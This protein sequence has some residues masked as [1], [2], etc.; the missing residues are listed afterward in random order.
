MSTISIRDQRLAGATMLPDDFIDYYMPRANGDFVKIYLFLLRSV[1]AQT[2]AP[3]ISSLAD[4]FRL[5]ERDVDRA[6]RYWQEAGLLDLKY[7]G[8]ELDEIT[9]LPVSQKLH[10]TQKDPVLEPPA[11]KEEPAENAAQVTSARMKELKAD[12]RTREEVRN[13]L[14]V[15]HQYLGH[16]LSQTDMRRLLYLY[17]DLQMSQELIDYLVD[18]CVT[19]GST[20]MHYIMKVG[21]A[22]HDEGITTVK[23]AKAR[24]NLTMKNYYT[25]FR[26]FGITGRSP[27][28]GE[29]ADMDRWMKEY[30]FSLKIIEEAA[31]RTIRSTGKPSFPYAERILSDWHK[32]GVRRPADIAALDE[33]HKAAAKDQH[34]I[35]GAGTVGTG[36]GTRSGARPAPVPARQPAGKFGNFPQRSDEEHRRLV[37]EVIRKQ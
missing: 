35:A 4:V 29:I 36:T 28:P 15:A 18:Y 20:S 30:G 1:H 6:L 34:G 14:Y 13:I 17:D 19:R 31:S 12:D 33:Q 16:P 26:A 5:T 27:V 22:W 8:E 11:R 24:N 2:P 9:L 23:D 7:K 37:E 25:I 10:E 32:A 3:T 21:L